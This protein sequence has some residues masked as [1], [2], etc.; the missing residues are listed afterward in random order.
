MPKLYRNLRKELFANDLKQP[1]V[2]KHIGCSGQHVSDMMTGKAEWRLEQCYKVL[3]MINKPYTDL[4]KYFP[5][6]GMYREGV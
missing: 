6:G 3:E 4:P 5:P 2:G 1:Y